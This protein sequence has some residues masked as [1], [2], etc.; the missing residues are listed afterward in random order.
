MSTPLKGT[1]INNE[2]LNLN[3]NIKYTST[4]NSPKG[5]FMTYSTYKII[6]VIYDK[7]SVDYCGFI[8][9]DNKKIVIEKLNNIEN[10]FDVNSEFFKNLINIYTTLNVTKNHYNDIQT[11]VIETIKNYKEKNT[12]NKNVDE[13]QNLFQNQN[14]IQNKNV[15]KNQNDDKQLTLLGGGSKLKPK[16]KTQQKSS[17]KSTFKKHSKQ[18]RKQK[19]QNKWKS[20]K[21]YI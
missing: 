3:Y 11:F 20:Q 5:N 7:D 13:N 1:V 9:P 10:G 21:N 4:Y 16:S 17:S 14:L 15:D 18:N 12:P 8:N 19:M 6:M 2:E